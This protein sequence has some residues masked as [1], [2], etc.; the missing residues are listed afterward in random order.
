M[1]DRQRPG[2]AVTF[3][4]PREQWVTVPKTAPKHAIDFGLVRGDTLWIVVDAPRVLGLD[5]PAPTVAQR[6]AAQNTRIEIHDADG[7]LVDTIQNPIARTVGVTLPN[8]RYSVRVTAPGCP[9]QE[10][11]AT[12]GGPNPEVTFRF[13]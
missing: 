11:Q 9:S 3:L 12:V 5:A 1:A 2:A 6:E 4:S 7:N 10:D 13:H 8:G